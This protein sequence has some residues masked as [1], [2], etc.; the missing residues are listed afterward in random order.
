MAAGHKPGAGGQ[1]A[2]L[3]LEF[4]TEV[5]REKWPNAPA[6]RDGVWPRVYGGSIDTSR[7]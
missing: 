4:L 1:R 3:T 6:N 5:F 2:P 7:A